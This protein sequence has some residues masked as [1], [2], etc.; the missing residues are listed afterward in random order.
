MI[1]GL[2][3]DESIK[4]KLSQARIQ[5]NETKS[6]VIAKPEKNFIP[7]DDSD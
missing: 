1:N 2:S 5:I 3:L 6:V 7:N 4:A